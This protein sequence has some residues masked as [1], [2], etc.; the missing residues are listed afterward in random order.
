M[1]MGET[2]SNERIE[3]REEL[4]WGRCG[5]IGLAQFAAGVEKMR[6]SDATRPKPRFVAPFVRVIASITS[7][8]GGKLITM[9]AG[10]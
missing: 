2:F 7:N 10:K 8:Y 1:V 9:T 5:A 6:Y 3:A 4:A